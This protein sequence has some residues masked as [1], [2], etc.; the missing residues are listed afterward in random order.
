MFNADKL[1]VFLEALSEGRDLSDIPI[2]VGDGKVVGA[3]LRG[4]KEVALVIGDE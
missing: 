2:V 4:G 3:F 1:M